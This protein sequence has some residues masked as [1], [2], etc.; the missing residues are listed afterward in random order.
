[1]Y[2]RR[3][4]VFLV[5]VALG[6][7]G[8]LLRLGQLQIVRGE[9]YL[10]DAERFL[11]RPEYLPSVRGRILDRKGLILAID[12]PCY[13]MCLDYGFVAAEEKWISIAARQ[14]ARQQ[15]LT[16]PRSAAWIAVQQRRIRS[17]EKVSW[18]QAEEIFRRRWD[19]TWQLVA[20]VAEARGVALQETVSGLVNRIDRM[21]GGGRR[22]IVEMGESHAIIR[23]LGEADVDP[24]RGQLEETVGLIIRPSQRRYYPRGEAAAH[25][26]GVTGQVNDDE[27]AARNLPDGEPD[28]LT[29]QR[30][31]YLGGDVVGKTGAE[32]MCET[33]LRGR[34]G[35]RIHR[36]GEIVDEQPAEPGADVHLTIDIALQEALAAAFVRHRPDGTGAIVVIDVATGDVLALVSRPT[37]DLNLYRQGDYYKQ[38]IRD[39]ISLPLHH[40]AVRLMC[41]PGSTAKPVAALAAL[42]AGRITPHTSF[43][44]I[45]G[46]FGPSPEGGPKCWIVH[47][48][49]SHGSVDLVGGLRQSCNVY[50]DHVGNVMGP[51][52]L[53]DWYR[54]FGFAQAPGTGLG[55]EAAG[56]LLTDELSRRRLGRGMSSGD[57]WQMAI[58]QGAFS[59]TPLQV[60]N[61]MATVARGGAYLSPRVSPEGPEQQRW[62]LPIPRD[63]VA[64]VHEG[65]RQVVHDSGGT[66]HRYLAAGGVDELGFQMCGKTGTAQVPPQRIDTNDDDEA[67]Q[68]VREG[69][70]AWFSGFAPY[71]R[72]QVAFAVL[73]EYAGGGGGEQAGPIALEVV[74]IC[75]EMGYIK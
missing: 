73:V 26:I 64:A 40:R 31:S 69:D 39:T 49:G 43:D 55:D 16:L 71:G 2:K 66:A 70:N 63:G 65:M 15:G 21:S 68:V 54:R 20:S 58:G 50:F 14:A 60:A 4:M 41:A 28:R 1:M 25:V 45:G 56:V 51:E 13:D 38:L 23:G 59:A 27:M 72:P 37:F 46:L 29:W 24:L 9:D 67:D 61:A 6:L 19:R 30:D 22:N 12:E 36:A 53:T 74:R 7:T 8:L 75:H 5:I 34:R 35:Y 18:E 32:K 10:R 48:G 33:I 42:A 57:A 44:C 3:V 47:S 17:R 11:R 52:L 62:D